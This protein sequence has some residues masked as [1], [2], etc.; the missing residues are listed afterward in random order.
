[1]TKFGD[2]IKRIRISQNLS[3]QTFAEIFNLTRGNVSSYEE[4]RAE[5]KIETVLKIANHFSI[6]VEDFIK[7]DIAVASINQAINN[8]SAPTNLDSQFK[9]IPFINDAI[10]AQCF[11]GNLQFCDFK[12]FPKLILPEN[13]PY[14]LLAISYH[15]TIPQSLDINTFEEGDV[16]I[17]RSVD[18]DNI[19][20]I[21]EKIGLYLHKR[22]LY[23]ATYQSKN[24]S[25]EL[26]LNNLKSQ[27]LKISTPSIF[28]KLHAIYKHF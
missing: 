3:Q 9:E 15:K 14:Q 5:P 25:Y 13:N 23:I 12:A 18:Q 7:E 4:H 11:Q 27:I 26:K 8:L 20:T 17:F 6:N 22:E 16:M 28:W 1:M 2:N 10:F 21:N 19:H 24:T